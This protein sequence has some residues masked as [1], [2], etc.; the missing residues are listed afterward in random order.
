MKKSSSNVRGIIII[1]IIIGIG[2]TLFLLNPLKSPGWWF[3]LVCIGFAAFL[4]L[5]RRQ[6]KEFDQLPEQIT[7]ATIVAKNEVEVR[8]NTS[9]SGR[10]DGSD[11]TNT[12]RIYYK[13]TFENKLHHQWTFDVPLEFFNTVLEGDCG[14]LIYKETKQGQIF[15]IGFSRKS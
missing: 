11:S 12:Y 10:G 7:E 4:I 3:G 5:G 8:E 1:C 2:L 9:A 15:Y 6:A 13:V 14:T